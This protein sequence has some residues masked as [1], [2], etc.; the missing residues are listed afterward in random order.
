MALRRNCRRSLSNAAAQSTGGRKIVKIRSGPSGAS[1]RP[2][3]EA[4]RQPAKH[5]DDGVGNGQAPGEGA[6][7]EHEREKQHH[8]LQDRLGLAHRRYSSTPACSRRHSRSSMPY[9]T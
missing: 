1:G 8:E 7:R 6:E 3:H 2:G 5:E 4:E 9:T